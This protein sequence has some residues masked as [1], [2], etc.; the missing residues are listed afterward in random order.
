MIQARVVDIHRYYRTGGI[1]WGRVKANFDAV[2]I[3]AAVGWM[4]D[5]LLAEHIRHCKEIGMPFAT[6]MI[7]DVRAGTMDEQA[8][9]YLDLPGVQDGVM[10]QDIESPA[11]RLGVKCI[12]SVDGRRFIRYLEKHCARQPW[13]YVNPNYL[14]ALRW[15]DWAKGY[16]MWLAQWPYRPNSELLYDRFEPFLEAYRGKLP[17]FLYSSK[18]RKYA[19]SCVLW[20]FTCKGDAQHYLANAHTQDAVYRGGL[21]EADLSVSLV[22]RE[23]FLQLFGQEVQTVEPPVIGRVRVMWAPFINLRSGPGIQYPDVGDAMAGS[24]W[25]VSEEGQD[26][27]GNAWVRGGEGRWLARVFNGVVKAEWL[28]R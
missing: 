10:M 21:K 26:E 1:D 7:P 24:E 12:S 2:I 8:A 11:P 13:N 15:P 6:Y 27:A 18:G 28:N 3:C 9:F 16:P 25:E 4:A 5:R 22:E 17:G 23:E 19:E 14:G 20:Q